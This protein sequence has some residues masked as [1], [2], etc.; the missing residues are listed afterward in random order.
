MPTTAW[1]DAQGFPYCPYTVETVFPVI[2]GSLLSDSRTDSAGCQQISCMP[3][4]PARYLFFLVVIFP[5][6]FLLNNLVFAFIP[7]P[8]LLDCLPHLGKM[9][10]DD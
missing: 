3:W 1:R 6:S 2:L 8:Q 4:F 5:S 9:G 10:A 7:Q